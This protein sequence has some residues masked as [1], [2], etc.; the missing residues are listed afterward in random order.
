MMLC[1]SKFFIIFKTIVIYFLLRYK[2]QL[3]SKYLHVLYAFA[4]VNYIYFEQTTRI[5][6]FY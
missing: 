6:N 4:K 3:L 1:L 2:I 5:C